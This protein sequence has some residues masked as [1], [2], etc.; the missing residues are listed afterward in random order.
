MIVF[1]VKGLFTCQHPASISLSGRSWTIKQ[2]CLQS[3]SQQ[4]MMGWN[5][6]TLEETQ[7]LRRNSDRLLL[8]DKSTKW[9]N[10]GTFYLIE[11]TSYRGTNCRTSPII[12]VHVAPLV[13]HHS[14]DFL[15]GTSA[16]SF[17][18]ALRSCGGSRLGSAFHWV[19]ASDTRYYTG[20]RYQVVHGKKFKWSSMVRPEKTRRSVWFP[21]WWPLTG[22]NGHLKCVKRSWRKAEKKLKSNYRNLLY[23]NAL[24]PRYFWATCPDNSTH[25]EVVLLY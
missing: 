22:T 7:R 25:V 13:S 5:P 20:S 8:T 10:D 3:Y 2:P 14:I 18:S 4:S 21:S 23:R 12:I 6:A 19:V 15:E 11:S 1:W 9:R 16:C 24:T 17:A